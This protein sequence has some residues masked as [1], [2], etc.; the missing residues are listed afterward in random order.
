MRCESCKHDNDDSKKFCTSC[1]AALGGKRCPKGHTIPDGLTDCPFCPRPV[2]AATAVEPSLANAPARREAT[3]VVSNSELERSGVQV[4]PSAAA[5][6]AIAHATPPA[7]AAPQGRSRTVFRPPGAPSDP[8]HPPTAVAPAATR[9][10]GSSSFPSPLVGFLVSFSL[11]PNGQHWPIRFGRTSIGSEA[12]CEVTVA[13]A[14]V[15][16]RHAEIMVRDNKGSVKI[17]V[18]DN[19]STNGTKLNG[20]DIF[21]DRPDLSNGDQ[22]SIADISFMFVALPVPAPF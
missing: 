14:G 18:S 15:S 10:A 16:G 6:R 8:T 1:G 2:R 17:W 12:G 22:V 19:N 20:S 13:A 5:S 9:I 7:P 11:D 21:T 3:A 4:S